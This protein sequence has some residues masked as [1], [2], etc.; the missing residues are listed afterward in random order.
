MNFCWL[1]TDRRSACGSL[2][3]LVSLSMY[4]TDAASA[5]I[6]FPALIFSQYTAYM[7]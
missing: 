1:Y 6:Q 5:I 7:L 3:Q 4:S 2:V